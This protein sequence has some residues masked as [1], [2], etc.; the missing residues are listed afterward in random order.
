MFS[1]PETVESCHPSYNQLRCGNCEA[2]IGARTA[3]ASF[4]PS[5]LGRY[6][7]TSEHAAIDLTAARSPKLPMLRLLERLF[8]SHK[9]HRTT[10]NTLI[11]N[12]SQRID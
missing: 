12:Q 7:P 11:Q 2:D 4:V 5:L 10:W 6:D 1:F 9:R 3:K 8:W